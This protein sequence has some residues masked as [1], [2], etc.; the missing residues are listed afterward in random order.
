MQLID[1]SNLRGSILDVQLAEFKIK[2]SFDP[3]LR[4]KPKN[5]KAKRREKEKQAKYV[6]CGRLSVLGAFVMLCG[7]IKTENLYQ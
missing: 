4:R 5:N 7:F 1:E 3:T 2:G 6:G